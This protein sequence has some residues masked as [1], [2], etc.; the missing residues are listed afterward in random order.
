LLGKSFQKYF[1]DIL[2]R[3]RGKKKRKEGLDFW[4][5]IYYHILAFIDKYE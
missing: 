1:E 4:F 3:F 2:K 5:V